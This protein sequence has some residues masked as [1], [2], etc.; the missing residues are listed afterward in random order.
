MGIEHRK[1]IHLITLTKL[2]Q[3]IF[4]IRH[5]NAFLSAKCCYCTIAHFVINFCRIYFN[6]Q[7]LYRIKPL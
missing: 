5:G 6:T 7:F 3:F 4:F 1:H 2:V